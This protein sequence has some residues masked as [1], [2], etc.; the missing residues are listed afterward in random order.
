MP[1]LDFANWS[2]QL[3]ITS[4]V[5]ISLYYTLLLVF[6]PSNAA[7]FKARTKVNALRNVLSNL[8]QHQGA[9]LAFDT[10]LYW[11]CLLTSQAII[12]WVYFLP[13][14]DTVVYAWLKRETTLLAD[15][16]DLLADVYQIQNV[17]L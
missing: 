9:A 10:E 5:V 8:F 17:S 6:L 1:Q 4:L 15:V 12:H 3:L 2:S 11:K 16:E 14:T 7:V 13:G